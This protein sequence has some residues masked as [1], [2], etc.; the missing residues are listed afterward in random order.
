MDFQRSN[1]QP[2]VVDIDY[3]DPS[4]M[5]KNCIVFIIGKR[6]SG[7]STVAEHIMSYHTD[8]KEGICISKTDKMNGFW[9]RHL[10]PLFIH[11]N[12]SPSITYKLLDHQEAKW[13][14]HKK[15]CKRQ[16]IKPNLEDIEPVFAIYDDITYDKSFLKD[17][18]TRELFMNGRHYGIL[19]MI[20]CQYLMDIG[21][22]LRG[23]I[24]YVI[25]LKD[26]IKNNR[27]KLYEYFAGVFPTFAAFDKTFVTC[28]DNREALVIFNGSLEHDIRKCVFFYLAEPDCEYT[29]GSDDYWTYS[30]SNYIGDENENTLDEQEAEF[31]G[32]SEK[33]RQKRKM[34]EVK[35]KYPGS[36]RQDDEQEEEDRPKFDRVPI[37]EY[38]KHYRSRRYTAPNLLSNKQLTKK[39]DDRPPEFRRYDKQT[40]AAPANYLNQRQKKHHHLHKKKHHF[41]HIKAAPPPIRMERT[42]KVRKRLKTDIKEAFAPYEPFG[43]DVLR[44]IENINSHEEEYGGVLSL[45][46]QNSEKKKKKKTKKEKKKE[47]KKKR[48]LEKMRKQQEEAKKEAMRDQLFLY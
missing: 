38:S 6:G 19:I 5:K 11:H 39:V 13:Q 16:G 46:K 41:N 2:I 33:E 14:K 3:F 22:D 21:P 44:S 12:Y 42:G 26:N 36:K 15:E 40:V 32:M 30:K 31:V 17:K 10:P 4:S 48:Q 25:T 8:I 47:E 28:T 20:T 29:L 9:T 7:K 18:A 45:L 37:G 23:Q 1:H 27:K 43:K 34:F 24:D 35:K